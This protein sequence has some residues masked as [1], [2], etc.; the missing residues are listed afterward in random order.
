MCGPPGRGTFQFQIFIRGP[1]P[2]NL[3]ETI[4]GVREVAGGKWGGL[5]LGY[6]LGKKLSAP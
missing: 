5:F 6:L 2:G 4:F 3:G 1:I